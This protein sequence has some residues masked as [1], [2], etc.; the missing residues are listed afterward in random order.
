MY[1]VSGKVLQ[2]RLEVGTGVYGFASET[3]DHS[4]TCDVEQKRHIFQQP[5]QFKSQENVYI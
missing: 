1:K 5:K 2:G 4:D 3:K